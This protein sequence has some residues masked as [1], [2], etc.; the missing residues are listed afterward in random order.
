MVSDGLLNPH[1]LDFNVFLLVQDPDTAFAMGQAARE[2]VLAK[3][4]RRAFGE[5]LESIMLA[6]VEQ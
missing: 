6:M 1:N 4:S 2:H 5:Q 3:F